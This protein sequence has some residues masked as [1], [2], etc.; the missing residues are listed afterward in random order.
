MGKD[1]VVSV[2]LRF[3]PPVESQPYLFACPEGGFVHLASYQRDFVIQVEM[4]PVINV[5]LVTPLGDHFQPADDDAAADKLPCL[6][7]NG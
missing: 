1:R 4:Q 3:S 6:I 2:H 5:V 7:E